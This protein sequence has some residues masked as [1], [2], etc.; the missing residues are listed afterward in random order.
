MVFPRRAAAWAEV[1]L[2]MAIR[3][4]RRRWRSC[5]VLCPWGV[6]SDDWIWRCCPWLVASDGLCG[7]LC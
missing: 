4:V 3:N 2:E 7:F 5:I 6:E 1:G